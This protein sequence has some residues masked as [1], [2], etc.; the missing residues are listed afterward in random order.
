MAAGTGSPALDLRFA[1][2]TPLPDALTRSERFHEIVGMALDELEQRW[3]R[4]LAGV[5]FSVEDVPPVALLPSGS[6]L[7]TADVAQDLVP[8][9]HSSAAAAASVPGGERSP[10]VVV[11][12]RRPIEARSRGRADLAELVFDV[13]VHELADLLGLTPE[14]IDPEGHGGDEE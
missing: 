11:L 6:D 14:E 4:E 9:S 1:I 2:P 7:T 13:L 3:A 12:F 5:A 8:L 10:A